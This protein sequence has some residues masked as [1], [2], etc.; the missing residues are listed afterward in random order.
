MMQEKCEELIVLLTKMIDDFDPH[1]QENFIHARAVMQ[2]ADWNDG[3]SVR[4]AVDAVLG[5]YGGIGSINDIWASN[6]EHQY[7]WSDLKAAE[8]ME[9]KDRLRDLAYEVKHAAYDSFKEQA[10]KEGGEE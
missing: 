3:E 7:G 1:W 6:L 9:C 10:R 2:A 8:F 4:V 5:M